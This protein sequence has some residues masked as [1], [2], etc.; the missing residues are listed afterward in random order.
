MIITAEGEEFAA[1]ISAFKEHI[2]RVRLIPTAQDCTFVVV[3]NVD[4]D[5]V[6]SIYLARQIPIVGQPDKDE[7]AVAGSCAVLLAQVVSVSTV[8]QSQIALPERVVVTL[9]AE[10]APTA[11]ALL[12][13]LTMIAE[14]EKPVAKINA[15]IRMNIAAFILIPLP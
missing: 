4:T 14:T 12:A 5:Q 3:V 9:N 11:S 15:N 1:T 7:K 13:S 6:A 2:V 8:R 10:M